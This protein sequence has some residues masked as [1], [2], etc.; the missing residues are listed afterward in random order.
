[1]AVGQVR[2]EDI[3][4]VIIETI[5]REIIITTIIIIIVIVI[6]VRIVIKIVLIVHDQGISH[7]NVE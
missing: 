2:I 6:T 3:T 5:S 4:G 1:M 7:H